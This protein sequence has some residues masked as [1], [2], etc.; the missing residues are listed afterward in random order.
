MR[1]NA[2]ADAA[3]A[4]ADVQDLPT[5]DLRDLYAAPD[6]PAVEADFTRAEAAARAFAHAHQGKLASMSGS[7]LAAV[8][9][10][11]ERMAGGAHGEAGAAP[12]FR[13]YVEW[14]R[15][16]DCSRV[17]LSASDEGLPLYRERGFVDAPNPSLRRRLP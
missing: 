5:W 13:R 16:Q 12:P 3:T 4:Q 6:S 17:E 10:E 2:P 14:L 9:G 8:I 7:V 11:Y 1:H 15:D